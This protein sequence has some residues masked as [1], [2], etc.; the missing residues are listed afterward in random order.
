MNPFNVNAMPVD[1]PTALF[2][3]EAEIEKLKDHIEKRNQTVVLGVEGVGKTSLLQSVFNREYRIQKA[4]DHTLISPVT[5]FPSGLKNDDI[6]SH[7][8]EMMLSSVLILAQ[9]DK[10]DE[11][12]R[13]LNACNEERRKNLKPA[14]FFEKVMNVFYDTYGYRIVMIVDNFER[15][16]AST[17]VTKVHHEALRM[18][19]GKSQY[20]VATNYDLNQDSLPGDVSGSLYLQAFA[21]NEISIGGWSH[22]NA[23]DYIYSRLRTAEIELS[24]NTVNAIIGVSGGIPAILNIAAN[25]AYDYVAKN[26]TEDGLKFKPLFE[27]NQ[28]IKMLFDHWCKMLLPKHITALTHLVENNYDNMQ[29]KP[30]LAC[31]LMRG[32]VKERCEIDMFGHTRPLDGVYDFCCKFFETYCKD[33]SNMIAA[34]EKNPLKNAL[35]AAVPSPNT[36]MLEIGDLVELLKKR[37]E[38]IEAPKEQLLEI[39]NQFGA[40]MPNVTGAIDLDEELTDDILSSYLLSRD[41]MSKFDEKV[42]DFLFNGIQMDRCFSNITLTGF[43]YSLVYI[44]FCKAVEVHLNKTLVPIIKT[45]C[46]NIIYNNV[47]P[48]SALP[49]N[50][51][52]TLGTISYILSKRRI[53]ITNSAIDEIKN[54]CRTN[55]LTQYPDTWWDSILNALK[56]IAAS[57]NNCPHCSILSDTEGKK[58]LQILFSSNKNDPNKS[59]M[60]KCVAAYN[61]LMNIPSFS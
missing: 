23:A 13:I 54:Y 14:E 31:L 37:I 55:Q 15:F 2:G 20:I 6:Y 33:E 1:S 27:S 41:Y 58:L 30:N 3:R 47:S 57:R 34:A 40:Y 5:E 42:R 49:S 44:S 39:I 38:E 53:G 22:D 8:T 61:D 43:D 26:S 35:K 52:L 36:D 56:K 50:E 51:T 21:G 59:F 45:L 11:M 24:E 17:E 48:I 60:M 28:R 7:F 12:N 10:S 29:D 18:L 9:C 32:L 16:T 46:P 19:L 4:L 25:Y